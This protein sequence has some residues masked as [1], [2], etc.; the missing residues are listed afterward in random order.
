MQ[1]SVLVHCDSLAVTINSCLHFGFHL[2]N[3]P[4]LDRIWALVFHDRP[5]AML[6]MTM[7]KQLSIEQQANLGCHDQQSLPSTRSSTVHAYGNKL[8][9]W[10]RLIRLRTDRSVAMGCVWSGKL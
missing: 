5:H 2:G 6:V 3:H 4:W 8:V 10:S 1:A 9:S 7:G